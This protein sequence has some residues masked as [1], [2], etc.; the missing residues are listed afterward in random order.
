MLIGKWK[1]VNITTKQARNVADFLIV[2]TAIAEC[3]VQMTGNIVGEVGYF[4][5]F[6]QFSLGVLHSTYNI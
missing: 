1:M 4:L 2:R 6:Y 3:K 5:E